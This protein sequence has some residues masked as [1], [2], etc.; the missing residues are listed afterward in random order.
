MSTLK[1]V[2]WSLVPLVLIGCRSVTPERTVTAEQDV[3][4]QRIQEEVKVAASAAAM[5]IPRNLAPADNSNGLVGRRLVISLS[6]GTAAAGLHLVSNAVSITTF[7]G[8]LE[9]MGNTNEGAGSGTGVGGATG[10]GANTHAAADTAGRRSRI[11]QISDVRAI[12][13]T[14]GRLRIAPFLVG[15]TLQPQTVSIDLLVTP[16][17]S[18]LDEMAVATEALW[19]SQLHPL[20]PDRAAIS[21][22]P[23]RHFTMY[24]QVEA[25]LSLDYVVT[26]SRAARTQWTCSAENRFTLVD[27]T[28]TAPN[29]WDLRKPAEFGRSEWW[30]ALFSANAGPFRAIFTSPAD[31]RGFAGWLRQTHALRV[32]AY[33]VGMFRPE[34]SGEAR[35]TV[36]VSHSV[37][38][39]FRA[40]SADD[41]DDLVVGRLG[42]L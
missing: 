6:P 32:G 18:P 31:A 35:R 29:L 24:D 13:V 42:E 7:G 2:V 38:D 26:R 33:Q 19:D 4:P 20:S 11:T 27:R 12:D 40:V 21:L 30:L 9:G 3:C 1:S 28:A 8:T 5:S 16:G 39:T 17:G 15:S 10:S 36:P 22:T 14:P 23:L 25:T 37:A 41:L 34:Y